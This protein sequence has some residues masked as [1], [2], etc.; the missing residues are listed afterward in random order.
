MKNGKAD[1]DPKT[2]VSTMWMAADKIRMNGENESVLLKADKDSVYLI[3][4]KKKTYTGISLSQI[5]EPS[6]R[7]RKCPPGC[8]Q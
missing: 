3:D 4:N 6:A 2:Q 7:V 1:G 5:A 8:R